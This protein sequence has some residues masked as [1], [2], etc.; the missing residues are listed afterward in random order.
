MKDSPMGLAS[1]CS[2]ILR[3]PPNCALVPLAAKVSKEPPLSLALDTI[4]TGWP[5]QK[6][7]VGRTL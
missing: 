3:F 6:R 4:V 1:H 7:W 2:G 5:A